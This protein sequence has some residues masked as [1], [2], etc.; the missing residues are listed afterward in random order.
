MHE[1]SHTVDAGHTDKNLDP[2]EHETKKVLN[3]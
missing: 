1:E 3:I 2:V